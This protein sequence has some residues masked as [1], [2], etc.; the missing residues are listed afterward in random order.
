[1]WS[2]TLKEERKLQGL[3]NKVIRK[4]FDLGRMEWVSSVTEA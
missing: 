4:T 2:V 1:M 3:Q